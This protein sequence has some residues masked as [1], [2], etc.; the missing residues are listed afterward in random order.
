VFQLYFAK[1][2]KKYSFLLVVAK[3]SIYLRTKYYEAIHNKDYSVVKTFRAGKL[4]LFFVP[5]KPRV[6]YYKM[7][8]GVS[9][10]K[11]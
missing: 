9:C 11:S 10:G 6:R 5:M 3:K 7:G 2:V 8:D 4:A 1:I